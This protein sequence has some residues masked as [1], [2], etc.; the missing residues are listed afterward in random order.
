MRLREE[1]LII[2][3]GQTIFFLGGSWSKLIEQTLV[4]TFFEVGGIAHRNFQEDDGQ[5]KPGLT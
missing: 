4:D 2:A 5:L 3:L 1:K